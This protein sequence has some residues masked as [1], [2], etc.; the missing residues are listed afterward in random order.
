MSLSLLKII[1]SAAC[2]LFSLFAQSAVTRCSP[3]PLRANK[4]SECKHRKITVLSW[5]AEMFGKFFLSQ[6]SWVKCCLIYHFWVRY[7][8]WRSSVIHPWKAMTSLVCVFQTDFPFFSLDLGRGETSLTTVSPKWKWV[9][10]MLLIYSCPL[11]WIKNSHLKINEKH[12]LVWAS[13]A[14]MQNT[15]TVTRLLPWKPLG[16]FLP[17]VVS[18]LPVPQSP[19]TIVAFDI[20]TMTCEDE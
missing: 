20:V 18:R 8:C 5:D 7:L 16:V 11:V 14:S 3:P 17:G 12:T 4:P 9:S 1:Q 10:W 15:M 19:I 2:S 6:H 13:E